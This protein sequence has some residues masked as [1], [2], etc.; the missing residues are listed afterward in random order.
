MASHRINLRGPWDFSWRSDDLSGTVPVS[1][2]GTVAMP[3]EWRELFGELA[4][5]A[6]FRRK[7][8]RPTNLEPH[9]QVLVVCKELRGT[10]SVRLNDVPVGSFTSAEG[11]VEFDISTLMKHFN[12]LDVEIS[13]DPSRNTNLPGGLYGVVALEIRDVSFRGN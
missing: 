3:K 13:F 9:E 5:T 1:K 2:T 7:F 10:G 11:P 4:G 6:Q 12:E 8:H